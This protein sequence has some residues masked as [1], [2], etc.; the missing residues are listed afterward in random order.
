MDNSQFKNGGIIPKKRKKIDIIREIVAT[1]SRTQGRI[2]DMT[3][4]IAGKKCC[5]LPKWFTANTL[6][7][8]TALLE[9]IERL[10]SKHSGELND[11]ITKQ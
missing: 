10:D 6:A 7:I 8:N 4:I 9:L 5:R 1:K 3:D 2:C 11:S